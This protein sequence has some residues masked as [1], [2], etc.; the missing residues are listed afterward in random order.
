MAEYKI[1]DL[2]TLT[3]IKAHT[4]RIWEKRYGLISPDRTETKIRMYSDQE[5]VQLL[6]VAL[7]NKH[8]Y[9][10]S[11][12]ANMSSSEIGE[13]VQKLESNEDEDVS[14]ERLILSMVE[15][16]EPLFSKTLNSLIEKK[17]LEKTFTETIIHFLDR[18]GIM[19]QVGSITPAQEHFMSNLIRQK[20][21]SAIDA[22]SGEK[23]STQS[24]LLYLPEHEWHELSL[25][26]YQF[27][28]RKRGIKTYYLGQSVPYDSIVSCFGQLK[29]D[30]IVTSWL[31]SVDPTFMVQ[32]FKNLKK[33]LNNAPI[34]VGG[35]QMNKNR[36]LIGDLV[37]EIKTIEDLIKGISHLK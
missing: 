8:G 9:K 29:P 4:I 17:G 32:Y 16:D 11:K 6:N 30:V 3:G 25:L 13:H 5:L 19:W 14:M 34:L 7:L 18:I 20:V 26:F 37:S 31:T 10:I 21:I 15:I 24:V 33:D 27:V 35:F 36:E 12:I 23:T 22:L 1:S 2:E 28:L